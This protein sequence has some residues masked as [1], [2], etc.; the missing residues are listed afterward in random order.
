MKK[1]IIVITLATLCYLA[2]LM[3]LVRAAFAENQTATN[4]AGQTYTIGS[5]TVSS[6][7]YPRTKLVWGADGTVNDASVLAALPVTSTAS[8]STALT[9]TA[10]AYTAGYNIGGLLTIANLARVSGGG[11]TV[12]NMSL[13]DK[14]AKAK[15]VFALFFNANPTAT[16]FTDNV[17]L[18]INAADAAKWVCTVRL[19][20][21]HS[22]N[23][24]SL[25]MATNAGCAVKMTTGTSGYV[26]L[27]AGEAVT[28]GAVGD[29]NLVTT[30]YP[31]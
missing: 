30:V 31:D 22:Q 25:S 27:V 11:F 21:H 20:E 15:N 3:L 1:K 4:G 24:T 28:Y 13:T 8:T 12:Q 19:T 9:V 6:V 18:A 23:G 26:A 2:V 10:G 29:L 16:T 7:E 17:L 5:D 14:G